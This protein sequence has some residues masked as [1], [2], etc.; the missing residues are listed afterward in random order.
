MA[1]GTARDCPRSALDTIISAIV[2]ASDC[3][4]VSANDKDF[5]GVDIL[6]PLRGPV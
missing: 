1:E 2:K 3:V 4:M 5:E 6:N